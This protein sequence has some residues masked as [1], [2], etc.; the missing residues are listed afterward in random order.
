MLAHSR[1]GACLRSFV[2][3]VLGYDEPHFGAGFELEPLATLERLDRAARDCH[4]GTEA[5]VKLVIDGRRGV[6]PIGLE[7]DRDSGCSHDG[8]RDRGIVLEA[9]PKHLMLRVPI[10]EVIRPP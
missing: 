2:A 3:F 9:R 7:C 4:A 6:L 1:D 8:L 10:F 5:T